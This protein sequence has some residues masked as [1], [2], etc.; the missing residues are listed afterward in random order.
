MIGRR[1]MDMAAI[2]RS[3]L[4]PKRAPPPPPAPGPLNFYITVNGKRGLASTFLRE[5]SATD[6][7][8]VANPEQADL[9]F[10]QLSK[11][12]GVYVVGYSLYGSPLCMGL[13]GDL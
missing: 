11:V 13:S 1:P 12:V 8:L 4:I 3:Q 9:I 7:I 6:N 5:L 10:Q 2:A